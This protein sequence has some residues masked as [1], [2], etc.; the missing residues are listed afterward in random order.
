MASISLTESA[1]LAQNEFVAGIIEEIVTVNPIFQF[2]PFDGIDGNSLQFTRENVIGPVATVGV[3]DTEGTIGSGVATGDNQ[4]ERL[5][6]KDAAT[7]TTVTA[8]LTTIMGDA[9]VNGLIQATRS[10]DG[11]DQTAIQIA[12]KAKAAARKF[13][14]MMINGDGTNHTFAGLL[15]LVT[16]TQKAVTGAN[17]RTFDFDVLD[18]LI[19][20]VKDKDGQVD[21]FMLPARTIRAYF[22]KLRALGGASI[23]DTMTLPNGG[24]IPVY[25]GIPLFQNDWIPINQTKGSGTALTTIFAGNWDD[26]SRTKGIAG[27][28]AK[29]HAGLGVEPVGVSE[30][31]DEKIWRVKWYCSMANFSTL[32]I[33]SAD[34]I[35]D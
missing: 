32:G 27:L 31:K 23:N 16:A 14:D 30:T 33:A 3:G 10:G 15:N 6:A 4:A 34:G 28:T 11:N 22:S 18:E 5:A 29:K 24:T 26:G 21:W 9:E 2:M 17:G 1:K 7:H 13:Q 35:E 12:S 19:H 20:L 25:R 8:G